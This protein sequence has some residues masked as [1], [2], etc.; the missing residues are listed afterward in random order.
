MQNRQSTNVTDINLITPHGSME[1]SYISHDLQ[2]SALI[3][4]TKAK[5]GQPSTLT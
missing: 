1:E 3:F 4:W 2:Q 5:F